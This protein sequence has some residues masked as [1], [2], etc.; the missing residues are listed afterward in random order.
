MAFICII[1]SHVLS[2]FD[3]FSDR[4]GSI[5]TVESGTFVDILLAVLAPRERVLVRLL[6]VVRGSLRILL[7]VAG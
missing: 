5:A 7:A 6:R 4:S 2:S 3:K 1:S